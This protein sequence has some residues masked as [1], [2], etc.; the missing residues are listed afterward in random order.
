MTNSRK[1]ELRDLINKSNISEIMELLEDLI[2]EEQ[3]KYDNL[4]YSKQGSEYGEKLEENIELL[5]NVFDALEEV[6]YHISEMND[7]L[8][9]RLF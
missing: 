2:N 3:E 4:P 9:L 8:N 5:Q 7:C 1:K 6:D